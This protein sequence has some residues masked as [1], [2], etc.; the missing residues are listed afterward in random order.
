MCARALR[1]EGLQVFEEKSQGAEG[2]D[3]SKQSRNVNT[4]LCDRVK[5]LLFI[6]RKTEY[7]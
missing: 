7:H 5:V 3:G 2:G 4:G 6:L 1:W